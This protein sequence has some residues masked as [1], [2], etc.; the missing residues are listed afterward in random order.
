MLTTSDKGQS[1]IQGFE[2]CR[3]AT[4]LDEAGNPTI[5]WGHTSS[6][7]APHV[8]LGMT[9]TQAQADQIFRVDLRKVEHDVNRL[10]DSG[11][12]L[13]QHQFDALVSFHY[14]TGKLLNPKC[15]IPRLL[16]KG[17]YDLVP[18]ILL[19]YIR[20]NGRPSNGLKRRRVGEVGLWNMPD[21]GYQNDPAGFSVDVDDV[22]AKGMVKSKIGNSA[23]GG[24]VLASMDALDQWVTSLNGAA[25]KFEHTV[26]TASGGHVSLSNIASGACS[27]LFSPLTDPKV[28]LPLLIVAGCAAIWLW[29]REHME[30]NFI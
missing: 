1:F 5:A 6:A 15:S 27:V 28:F 8:S 25:L 22:T 20:S 13:T 3:L 26:A 23:I 4:Y 7:G 2:E 16:A 19:Q 30:D 11:I 14:N 12:H 29:R 9:V 24:G 18:G 21:E 10:I 17:Q